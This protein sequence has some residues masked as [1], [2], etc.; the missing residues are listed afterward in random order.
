MR[1]ITRIE[2]KIT[3]DDGLWVEAYP[4]T[5]DGSCHSQFAIIWQ[6]GDFIVTRIVYHNDDVDVGSS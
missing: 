2:A 5:S 1:L 3:L 6:K 4:Y